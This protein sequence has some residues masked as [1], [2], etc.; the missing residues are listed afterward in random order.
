MSEHRAAGRAK[1]IPLRDD[2]EDWPPELLEKLSERLWL[3]SEFLEDH[4][5]G[6]DLYALT[7]TQQEIFELMRLYFG[8]LGPAKAGTAVDGVVPKWQR[9]N[10]LVE[11]NRGKAQALL[12]R[13]AS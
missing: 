8:G 9:F 3:L 1:V 6:V 2:A 13:R 7:R 10:E 4:G 12:R 11:S 5:E